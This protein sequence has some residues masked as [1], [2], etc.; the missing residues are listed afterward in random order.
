MEDPG[1]KI[2]K[3]LR[4]SI[5]DGA[6][7][8]IMTGFGE[9]FFT[10]YAVF[11]RAS[12]FVIGLVG[13]LPQMIGYFSQ[14]LAGKMIRLF[15]SRQ[16]FICVFAL[17]QGL[18]HLPIALVYFCRDN[19]FFYLLLFI[20]LYWLLGMLPIPAWNSW[21][22]DLVAEKERGKYFGRRNKLIGLVNFSAFLSGGLILQK[23][24]SSIAGFFLLFGLA[25]LARMI[26]FFWLAIKYEPL[27]LPQAEGHKLKTIYKE[28]SSKNFRIFVLYQSLMNFALYMAAPFFA[29]YMLR[30]LKF[31]YLLF[32]VIT[33]TALLTKYL[34]MPLWGKLSDHYGTKKILEVCGFLMPLNPLLW[35][36]SP[37][38]W[39]LIIAQAYGGF[40]WAGFEL[41]SFVFVYDITPAER[42]TSAVAINNAIN[43]LAILSGALFS[44]YLIKHNTFFW[45][46]YYL[47]FL[48]S[49]FLRFLS[50][51][52][53]IPKLE[54]VRE[55]S[56]VGYRQLIIE[57]FTAITT[58]SLF[59]NLSFFTKN[60]K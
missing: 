28:L 8:S 12:N 5:L 47:V 25:F 48:I 38:V 20:S 4:Y 22:G 45:S 19:Q 21:M 17:L 44:A 34:A 31:D 57:I 15:G 6:F 58:K 33:A 10:A 13:S 35:V 2:R 41:A 9:S 39:W 7:F 27:Y 60:K 24:N 30:D 51:V 32:T 26:S 3:S 52:V 42:R 37:N 18:I 43:G 49:F 29:P 59:F 55:V 23:A 1:L 46:R 50:S 14:L 54:E 11:L 16:R 53:F 40:V 36:I 56:K